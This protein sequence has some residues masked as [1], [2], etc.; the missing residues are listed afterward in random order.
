MQK[1]MDTHR[2]AYSILSLFVQ[3]NEIMLKIRFFEGSQVLL[4]LTVSSFQQVMLGS[5]IISVQN[6]QC[7]AQ[8]IHSER[9]HTLAR[10]QLKAHSITH[11]QFDIQPETRPS[12]IISVEGAPLKVRIFHLINLHDSLPFVESRIVENIRHAS[13]KACNHNNGGRH[14]SFA[15]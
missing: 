7:L 11:S 13:L 12:L 9:I 2:Q 4:L 1:Q 15:W 8:S 5:K 3:N 10:W 14:F 6:H